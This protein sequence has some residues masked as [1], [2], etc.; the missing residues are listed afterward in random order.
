[1]LYKR[2]FPQTTLVK[3]VMKSP[4]EVVCNAENFVKQ[5]LTIINLSSE[6]INAQNYLAFQQ[7]FGIDLP[8]AQCDIKK[9]NDTEIEKLQKVCAKA[10]SCNAENAKK[11]IFF[12]SNTLYSLV[13]STRTCTFF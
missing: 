5:A 7:I 9:L 8:L 11:N 12:Y 13:V 6:L 1:M 4:N 10:L 2:Y 3:Y